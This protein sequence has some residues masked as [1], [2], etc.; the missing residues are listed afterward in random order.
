MSLFEG[1]SSVQLAPNG[2]GLCCP[3]V[4]RPRQVVSKALLGAELFY[5][6]HWLLIRP[7][8]KLCTSRNSSR[9]NPFSNRTQPFP[10]SI[11]NYSFYL[12]C[13][14][15]R[16]K[17][18]LKTKKKS[19]FRVAPF[20]FRVIGLR[21]YDFCFPSSTSSLLSSSVLE[22]NVVLDYDFCLR[23]NTLLIPNSYRTFS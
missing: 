13:Q 12:I 16:F 19:C 22:Q 11:L 20:V 5:E 23:N 18:T 17:F 3:P 10:F 1:S 6:D 14:L 7:Y 4:L 8:V 15:F 2:A 21:D 9:W